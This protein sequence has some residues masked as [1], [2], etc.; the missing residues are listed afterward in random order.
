MPDETDMMIAYRSDYARGAQLEK[1]VDPE[2]ARRVLRPYGVAM[3]KALRNHHV[4]GRVVDCGAGWG[5]LI[6]MMLEDGLE[7]CGVELSEQQVDYARRRGWP[8]QQGDL[9]V[10]SGEGTASAVTFLAVFEHLVNHA[11]VLS[12]ARRLLRDHGVVISLHPTA[13]FFR[14][15]GTL[16]TLGRQTRSLP[17][18]A[19]SFAAPWHT[20]FL[21]IEATR[22]IFQRS[23]FRVLEILPAPQGRLGGVAGVLQRALGLLN[24]IGWPVWGVRWPLVTSH[25]FVCRKLPT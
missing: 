14:L 4:T 9:S 12:D 17:D 16:A 23:G 18:L 25:I 13:A 21:S 5:G 3:M 8:I 22:L 6:E 19:G 10:L 11:R 7:A 2:W 20:S 1:Y 24:K 15:V